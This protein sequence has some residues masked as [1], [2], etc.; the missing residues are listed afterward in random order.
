MG[1]LEAVRQSVGEH[2]AMGKDQVYAFA[3]RFRQDPEPYK[4]A[5]LGV[6]FVGLSAG[7]IIR[8]N[9]DRNRDMVNQD[10]IVRED[11]PGAGRYEISLNEEI[12][13]LVLVDKGTG[14]NPNFRPLRY[15]G[16]GRISRACGELQYVSIAPRNFGKEE[17][18]NLEPRN[19]SAR[20]CLARLA[21][22]PATPTPTS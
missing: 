15:A 22:P 18:V 8:A 5:A 7:L 9:E 4:F 1:R 6:M 10:I 12:I 14:A 21:S 11:V 17:D 19:I 3:E 2:L 16:L 13:S 20:D